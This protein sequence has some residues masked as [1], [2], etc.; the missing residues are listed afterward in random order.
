MGVPTDGVDATREGGA[1]NLG[2]EIR[3]LTV[4]PLAWPAAVPVEEPEEAREVVEVEG[5]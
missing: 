4:H 2:E 5:E 3:E 1:M